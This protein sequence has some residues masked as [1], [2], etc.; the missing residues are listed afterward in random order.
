MISPKNKVSLPVQPKLKKIASLQD[1]I[2][3][4]ILSRITKR[5]SS[6]KS[7]PRKPKNNALTGRIKEEICGQ[8]E[9]IFSTTAKWKNDTAK[10]INP[11]FKKIF[12]GS[13]NFELKCL[14]R[15]KGVKIKRIPADPVTRRKFIMKQIKLNNTR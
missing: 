11:A 3:F 9:T 7:A 6:K 2:V 12:P 4:M 5:P 13:L 10:E 1:L 8:I 14:A 15:Y